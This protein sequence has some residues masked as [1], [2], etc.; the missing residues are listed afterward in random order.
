MADQQIFGMESS[1]SSLIPGAKV[2]HSVLDHAALQVRF[3][4]AP[5]Q[6]REPCGQWVTR[7]AAD[8][9]FRLPTGDYCLLSVTRQNLGL[10]SFERKVL[11]YFSWAVEGLLVPAGTRGIRLTA[12]IASRYS[13]EHLLIMRFVRAS[14]TSGHFWTVA[15]LIDQLHRLTFKQY[16]GTKCTSGFLFVSDY[17]RYREHHRFDTCDLVEFPSAIPIDDRFFE[18]PP[19][20][21]YVDGKNAFYITDNWSRAFGTMRVKDPAQFSRVQ[22]SAHAHLN[23]LIET[24]AC[25]AWVGYAGDNGDVNLVLKGGRHLRWNASHW[26]CVDRSHMIQIL[27]EHGAEATVC[28]TLC[29]VVFMLAEQRL[30]TVILLPTSETKRPLNAGRIDKATLGMNLRESLKGTSLVDLIKQGVA[31]GV[32]SS[33]GLTTI[34]K[35]GVV[36][37]CGDIIDLSNSGGHVGGGRTQAAVAASEF[38]VA[39]K[40]SEDGPISVYKNANRLMVY[41]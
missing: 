4:D 6:P 8:L 2:E 12:R 30:G 9:W 41:R 25:K 39:I 3:A 36:I 13:F 31:L 5:V 20:Y 29:D 37:G 24:S 11:G 34:S 17:L 35:S 1:L 19:S 10:S 28:R 27:E 32:L 16:E 14:R 40:V 22:R 18:E 26:T 7:E 21:R 38:G 15:N 23:Q 33:D